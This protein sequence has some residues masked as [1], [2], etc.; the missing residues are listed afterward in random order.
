MA[1]YLSMLVQVGIT[2]LVILL[3]QRVG[4][5]VFDPL[6]AIPGPF[7]ARFTRLWYTSALAKGNWELQNINLHRKYGMAMSC[8]R[9]SFV[10]RPDVILR[11]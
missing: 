1:S 9:V 11:A 3:L 10:S 7:L 6:R 5:A 8:I 2:C 4:R